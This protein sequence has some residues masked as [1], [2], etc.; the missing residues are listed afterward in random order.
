MLRKTII[1]GLAGLGLMAGALIGCQ[2]S[3][4]EKSGATSVSDANAALLSLAVKDS[5]ACVDLKARCVRAHRAWTCL[6]CLISH[7]YIRAIPGAGRAQTKSI[8][9]DRRRGHVASGRSSPRR[10]RT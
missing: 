7:A 1:Q 10:M 9:R 4:G 8:R 2:T 5:G 3:T 6:L